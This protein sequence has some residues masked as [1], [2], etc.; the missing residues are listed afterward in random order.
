[1]LVEQRDTFAGF[2]F[3]DEIWYIQQSYTVVDSKVNTL[4]YTAWLKLK[5]VPEE[6]VPTAFLLVEDTF[7]LPT[8]LPFQLEDSAVCFVC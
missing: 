1:M 4:E 3:A 7:D 6:T 8:A 2:T 5:T